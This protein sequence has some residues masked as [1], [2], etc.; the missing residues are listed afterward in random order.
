MP[1]D[2][3]KWDALELS[4]DSDIEVHPNVDKK[5]FIRAKQSQIHM[6]R[7]QRKQRMEALRYEVALHQVLLKRI[8][9]LLAALQSR[10]SEATTTG[11]P[12]QLAFQAVMESAGDAK[13]DALPPVPEG[14]RVDPNQPKTYS[15]MMAGLLD[16]VNK[17]MVAKQP[18]DRYTAMLEEIRVHETQVQTLIR[19]SGD[20]L[21]KLEQQERKKI[22]SADIHTGFDSSF[23]N[24]TPSAGGE[25]TK[26]ELL[27]PDY[28]PSKA[29]STGKDDDDDDDDGQ[30]SPLA[31]EFGKIQAGN[32]SASLEFLAKHREV[33]TERESDGL[34]MIAFDEA[35]EGREE[36]A[37]QYV[38]QAL[39]LQY[40]R[41]LGRDGVAL[42][43]RRVTE[44]EPN[45]AKDV[46]Y[47]DVR[48]THQRICKR[49]RELKA[50]RA[51]AGD[52]GEAQIQL[53]AVE[54]GTVIAINVPE[55]DSADPEVRE[56]REIFEGFSEEMRAA[57]ETGE[58]EQVN[59]VLGKMSVEEAEEYVNLFGEAGILSMEEE[60]IDGTTAEGRQKIEA[61]EAK[62]SAEKAAEETAG[63]TSDPE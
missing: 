20:E 9:A 23:V 45:N 18:D 28:D 63:V 13:D 60:I 42:F 43:F 19:E 57:L 1:L 47:K 17:A 52:D 46:F 11:E 5:S 2:Y 27:N 37:Q 51:A 56:A 8:S 12:G 49:A 6:E 22:T 16:Q 39:L 34:L 10:A 59:K 32:Y 50:E 30:P 58:L 54:P 36:S 38:H 53:H 33:L 15:A 44:K 62:H 48:D 7:Q 3:S 35:L 55:A 25:S 40:C 26:V 14:L 31:E 61:L 24:K 41:S 4:D 21:A 29:K